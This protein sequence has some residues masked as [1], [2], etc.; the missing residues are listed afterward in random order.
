MMANGKPVLV[1]GNPSKPVHYM[2]I[3]AMK[4]YNNKSLEVSVILPLLHCLFTER[5][6]SFSSQELRLE[7]YTQQPSSAAAAGGT[8]FSGQSP[9]VNHECLELLP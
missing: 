6:V 9:R 3:S 1:A 5:R 2:T 8:A 4:E 7:D